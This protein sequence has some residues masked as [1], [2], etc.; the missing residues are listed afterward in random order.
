MYAMS[1]NRELQAEYYGKHRVEAFVSQPDQVMV[2]RHSVDRNQE[3]DGKLSFAISFDSLLKHQALV[4]GDVIHISGM[5]P[6]QITPGRG[7][8]LHYDENR[9]AVRFHVQIRILTTEGQRLAQNAGITMFNVHEAVIPV[10]SC[11]DFVRR[12]CLSS[13][14]REIRC[15]TTVVGGVKN[16][17]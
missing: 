13:M 17:G 11:T 5:A 15:S 3:W 6:C 10:S 12:D 7:E 16:G 1:H 8:V 2:I 14:V 4:N 9:N